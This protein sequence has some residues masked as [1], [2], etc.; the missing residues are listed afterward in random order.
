M[1]PTRT[2]PRA[3]DAEREHTATV[4]REHAARGR[5]SIDELSHRLELAFAATTRGE[6]ERLLVDLPEQQEKS[7]DGSL[8]SH[9]LTFLAVNALLIS[10]WLL[11]GMGY[12]WPM[13]PLM[14]W[15]I[16]L[17]SHA[18]ERE[19]RSHKASRSAR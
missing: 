2:D 11:S 5:L 18:C 7:R 17:L 4:L 8:R 6:L 19:T 12:F 9:A 14:G 13:W 10:V 15:G 1:S 16:G 3:S